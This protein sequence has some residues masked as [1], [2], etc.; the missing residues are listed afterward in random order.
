MQFRRLRENLNLE[1]LGAC[2]YAAPMY[3]A[4]RDLLTVLAMAIADRANC[5]G[6]PWLSEEVDQCRDRS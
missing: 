3:L 6:N 1:V 2:H 5:P 4:Q